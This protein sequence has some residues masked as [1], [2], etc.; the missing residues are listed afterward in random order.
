MTMILETEKPEK[1]AKTEVQGQGGAGLALGPLRMAFASGYH[2]AWPQR[3]LDRQG[4][5]GSKQAYWI[6]YSL[7]Y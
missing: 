4:G 7:D 3:S 2:R 5:L 6:P 1:P